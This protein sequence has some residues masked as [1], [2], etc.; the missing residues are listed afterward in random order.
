MSGLV[1]PVGRPRGVFAG[2][3]L[4]TRSKAVGV[5]VFVYVYDVIITL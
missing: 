2:F 5:I 4:H 1:P 3:F